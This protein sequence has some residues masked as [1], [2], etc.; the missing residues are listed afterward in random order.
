MTLR[1]RRHTH[2]EVAEVSYQADQ[3]VGVLQ[4][5]R[6][7]HPRRARTARGVPAQRQQVADP[8]VGV[9][10]HDRAQLADLGRDAGEVPHRHQRGLLRDPARDAHGPPARRPAGA[11]R[12]RHERRAQRLELAQRVEQQLLALIGL[13][14]EE[15]EGERPA[16]GG[17]QLGDGRRTAGHDR[18][19]S[20]GHSARLDHHAPVPQGARAGAQPAPSGPACPGRT[21]R[22]PCPHGAARTYRRRDARG[23]RR[24]GP[25]RPRPGLPRR[26]PGA[27]GPAARRHQRR[28]DPV[29]RRPDRLPR[30]RQAAAA[31]VRLLGVARRGRRRQ[32]RRRGRRRPP[33]SCCRRAPWSTTT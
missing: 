26:V 25:P 15:L 18:G 3:L 14:R 21:E 23:S 17:E 28:A 8:G 29:H 20:A 1:E 4:A 7:L 31:G 6:V 22:L 19:E 24:R 30:R 13:G 2:A 16:A 32:R 9:L 10:A 33:S 5:A 12:H 27:A 11:V